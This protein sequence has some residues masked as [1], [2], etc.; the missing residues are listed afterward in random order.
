MS[1]LLSMIEDN[2][3]RTIDTQDVFMTYSTYK[4]ACKRAYELKGGARKNDLPGHRPLAI[5]KTYFG[6][7]YRV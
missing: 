5:S 6:P 1:R 2:P 4:N 3:P 7:K